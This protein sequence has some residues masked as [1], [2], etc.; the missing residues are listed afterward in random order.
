MKSKRDKLVSEAIKHSPI[1]VYGKIKPGTACSDRGELHK[2]E[3][4]K[5]KNSQ[6]GEPELV[7]VCLNCGLIFGSDRQFVESSLETLRENVQLTKDLTAFYAGLEQYRETERERRAGV[8]G[9]DKSVF[10]AGYKAFSEIEDEIDARIAARKLEEV[11][12]FAEK[13]IEKM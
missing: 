11:K 13:I 1:P 8:Y 3:E 9:L 12:R 2:W 7:Q 4:V 10:L 5:I 6:G